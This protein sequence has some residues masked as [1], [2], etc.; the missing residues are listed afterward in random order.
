VGLQQ[1]PDADDR[2]LTPV[3][4]RTA[5]VMLLITSRIT[6]RAARC[7]IDSPFLRAR[8]F[9][10]IAF[11]S[12]EAGF[13]F[14]SQSMIAEMSKDT[15]ERKGLDIGHHRILSQKTPQ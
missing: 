11:L 7:A 15:P 5:T 14:T 13:R 8:M 3:T 9:A 2:A 10:D 1:D 12:R 4:R 6:N